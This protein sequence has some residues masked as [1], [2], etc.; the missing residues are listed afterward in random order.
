M[1]DTAIFTLQSID[2]TEGII[3]ISGESFYG[4]FPS[5]FFMLKFLKDALISLLINSSASYQLTN[6]HSLLFVS[7]LVFSSLS[8]VYKFST[9]PFSSSPR[10]LELLFLVFCSLNS[11]SL[12]LNNG[13]FGLFSELA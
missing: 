6:T 3:Y 7:F 8:S 11:L 13:S 2:E 12:E 10:L 4:N 1:N 5:Q 9:S